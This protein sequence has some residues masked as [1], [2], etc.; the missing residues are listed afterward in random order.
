MRPNVIAM[1]I[2]DEPPYEING[3]V[4][5]LA[6]SN[7]TETPRFIIACNEKKDIAPTPQFLIKKSC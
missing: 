3:S 4:I 6:G 2:A 1:E 7:R 5:P